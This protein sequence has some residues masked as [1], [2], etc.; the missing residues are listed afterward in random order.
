MG[1]LKTVAGDS[2][3]LTSEFES[4]GHGPAMRGPPPSAADSRHPGEAICYPHKDGVQNSRSE[5]HCVYESRAY[6]TL[7]ERKSSFEHHP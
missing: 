4:E 3:K 2:A 1:R 7:F 6:K 5:T